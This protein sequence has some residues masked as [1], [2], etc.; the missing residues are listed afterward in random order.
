MTITLA[1]NPPEFY[2]DW[3]GPTSDMRAKRLRSYWAKL[4][5]RA[6]LTVKQSRRT[7]IASSLLLVACVAGFLLTQSLWIV[8]IAV[9]FVVVLSMYAFK[10]GPFVVRRLKLSRVVSDD[11]RGWWSDTLALVSVTVTVGLLAMAAAFVSAYT[12][13]KGLG[14]P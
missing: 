6:P 7:A 14:A 1:L 11:T 5:K 8:G 13:L 4:P 12:D 10:C 2:E 3:N 9:P